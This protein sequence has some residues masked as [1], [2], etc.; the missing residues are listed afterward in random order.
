[1]GVVLEKVFL[2]PC[3]RKEQG[4]GVLHPGKMQRNRLNRYPS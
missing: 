2:E 3:H 1:M 4:T